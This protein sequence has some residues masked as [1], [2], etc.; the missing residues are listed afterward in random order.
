MK[1]GIGNTLLRANKTKAARH[2]ILKLKMFLTGTGVG[3]R[4]AEPAGS[5]SC[6]IANGV[7]DP[8]DEL[9]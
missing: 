9:G 4:A 6:E 3:Q 7:L 1:N 5:K 8:C 2:P